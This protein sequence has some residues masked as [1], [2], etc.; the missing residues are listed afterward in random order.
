MRKQSEETIR[1]E[2]R[3]RSNLVELSEQQLDMVAGGV[4]VIKVFDKDTPSI[5]VGDTA[6]G[7]NGQRGTGG[8]IGP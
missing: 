5:F 8:Q 4:S 6:G 2:A 1:Q 7:T 3:E